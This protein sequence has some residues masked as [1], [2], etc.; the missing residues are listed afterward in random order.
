[1]AR[2]ISQPSFRGDIRDP[3][4]A[5][6]QK[7][8]SELAS[9]RT[10]LQKI[11]QTF[12][13]TSGLFDLARSAETAFF[14]E[15]LKALFNSDYSDLQ[16]KTPD[17]ALFLHGLADVFS[18]HAGAARASTGNEGE[19]QILLAAYVGAFQTAVHDVLAKL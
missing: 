10:R 8:E 11:S 3:L 5:L 16:G 4:S 18:T 14:T 6:D 15:K 12:T 2:K 13:S 19:L 9:H 17:L 1:V 7:L